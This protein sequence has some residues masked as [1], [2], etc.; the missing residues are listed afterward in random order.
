MTTADSLS[1]R[2]RL[3]LQK[4]LSGAAGTVRATISPRRPGETAPISAE[5]KDVWLHAAMAPDVPLYNEA[6]TI[7]RYGNLDRRALEQ[8]IQFLLDRHEIWRTSFRT[9]EGQ[10]RQVVEPELSIDIPFD[11]LSDLPETQSEERAR[12]LATADA[13]KPFDLARAPLLRA[14]LVRLAPDNHRLYLTLHHIIFDGVSIYRII[15]P[16]I[17]A[18]YASYAEGRKPELAPPLLQ[19][20]DYA[21]WR[22]REITEEAVAR[23]VNY[24]REQLAGD[25]PVVM[26]PADRRRPAR[27]THRGGMETFTLSG[28]LTSA[29][30]SL[31]R[32]TGFTLY[33]VLLGAF[34]TLLHRYGGQEDIVIGGVTDMRRRPE[35]TN[36]IGYFLNSIA[37]RTRPASHMPFRQY[38]D[39]V[40]NTVVEA[41]DASNVPFDRVVREVRPRRDAGAHP[42]F[43]V[44]F[45]I[46]PPPPAADGGWDLT[47]MDV[48]AGV[49][50]FDLYL[51][52]DE[53]PE[54]L[55]GRFL[56]STDIFDASTIRLMV[57]H[58]IRLLE[59]IVVD[60]DCTL[61]QLPLF[62]VEEASEL[63]KV[64]DGPARKYAD[65]ALPALFDA[66]ASCTPD[67]I[68]LECEGR[69]WRYRDLRERV[70]QL[71]AGLEQAGCGRDCLVAIMLDRDFDMVAGLLAILRSGAAYL[72]LDP[73]LPPVRLAALLADARPAAVLTQAA[74][75][76][77][78]PKDGPIPVLCEEAG[79]NATLEPPSRCAFND[80]AYLLFTS[81][82]TGKPK[83]VEIG[84]RSL[85][86]LLHAMVD[87]LGP[88]VHDRWLAV[89]TLSF[90][91]AALELFLPLVTGG[92]LVLATHEGAADPARLR[93]LLELSDCTIMQATPATWRGLI[94]AGWAGSRHLKILCG[95]E[96]LTHDLAV[97]LLERGS[98]LW[99]L[100][101]PTETTIWSLIHKVD[102]ND[103][104]VPIGRPLAN[105]SIHVL[106]AHGKAV[107][108]GIAGRLW[109][110]GAGLAQGYRNDPAQTASKFQDSG[111]ASPGRLY[112]T[113]DV[114]RFRG[115]GRLEFLGR[116][117]N[118][119]KIRG[120]RVGL[121]EIE[122]ALAEYPDVAAAAVREWP[123][124][125][126]EFGL[127]CYAVAKSTQRLDTVELARYLEERLPRYM[128]PSRWMVMDALPVTTSGKLNRAMLPRPA[129]PLKR[130]SQEPRDTLERVL[131]DLW[132]AL[133][134]VPDVGVNENFFE[135]GGHSL[136][137]AMLSADI[138]KS[139][140]RDLPLASLFDAPTVATQAQ[141]LRT[142]DGLRFSHLVSLRKGSGRPLFIVH[143]AFGQVL[144]FRPLAEH[145]RTGR[146][147]WAL[148]ARGADYRQTPHQRIEDMAAAYL[149]EICKVQPQ[150]PYAIAGYSFGGLIALEMA[151]RLRDAGEAVELLALI[152]TDVHASNLRLGEKLTHYR[153]LV[154]RVAHKLTRLPATVWWRYLVGKVDMILRCL[155][156]PL[157]SRDPILPGQTLPEDVQVRIREM[158][159]VCVREFVTY[160]PRRFTGRISMFQAAEHV[161]DM[162]DPLPLWRRTAEDVEV[163]TVDGN[164]G[165][166]MNEENV[167]SLARQLGHCLARLDAD[168]EPPSEPEIPGPSR[169]DE[170]PSRSIEL[171][172]EP[173]FAH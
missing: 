144:Q 58:W 41:L 45:S 2:K 28:E 79:P 7:H 133:L 127:V 93:A 59:G 73:A 105:T 84:H 77:R 5:Q 19:Y 164:H 25:L 129:Q 119:V 4:Q 68:A 109:I 118:Q 13:R 162:Y 123:D 64:R 21:L 114:V 3:L 53:R 163:F 20:S 145:L 50:K 96:S 124:G 71:Q 60:V 155:F 134:K 47:Q 6:L 147:L 30:K 103:D 32:E 160:R 169:R 43:Q 87:E 14:R 173:H 140:Q 15:V 90:D 151:C 61:G 106:D 1:A 97:Q 95:G 94:A 168:P 54:G 16:E 27:F 167:P 48:T 121:E 89:T 138:R 158:Y 102:P 141:L 157:A 104:P 86:N 122:A 88:G 107:P 111:E 80:L 35:L 172:S 126:G 152:D 18:V 125:S 63:S 146:P 22:E 36:V 51:E 153:T 120:F 115:D 40:Q 132:G 9:V 159:S 116:A 148:Q 42:V 171:S 44:L 142:M 33:V 98:G 49:A 75:A 24:W 161:F 34:K 38:L 76:H 37:L 39:Q 81:G 26:L 137:A 62:S 70:L 91:I 135:L 82:S 69:S 136:L 55:I 23:D 165:T 56:Y 156:V 143:G 31:S 166:V 67:A 78:L 12:D 10:L 113:G 99:N 92:R 100:Y 17:A 139:L 46:E 74:H 85:A 128:I 65:T 29:L 110:G 83:A 57:G 154:A 130:A 131:V 8:T 170:I 149:A 117:D 101:G 52:L 11:D 66:Q 150:G 112:D 72:P 108:R